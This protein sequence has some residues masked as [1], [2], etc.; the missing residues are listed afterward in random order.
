LVETAKIMNSREIILQR[1]RSGLSNAAAAGFGDLR[2][3]PTP[4]VWP[5][6]CPPPAALVAQFSDELN[7]LKGEPFHCE[8]IEAARQQ[9]AQLMKSD[10][11]S[12]IGC[13]DRPLLRELTVQIPAEQI[14]WVSDDWT[15][16]RIEQLPAALISAE[17]LL[18]DTGSCVVHC[19]TAAQRLMCYLPPVCI[20]AART[21]QLAEHLPAAWGPISAACQAQESRGEVVLITGPSRTADIEKKLILGVHGPKRL[22]VLV[23]E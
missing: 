3:P 10:G 4:E 20:I 16:E 6:K 8:T 14:D 23:V 13:L 5:R 12:R 2:E 11:W 22:I 9:L 15:A 21:G 18:A 1:I 7:L 17:A 19:A